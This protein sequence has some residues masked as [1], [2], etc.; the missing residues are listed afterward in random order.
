MSPK[1]V[2]KID[3]DKINTNTRPVKSDK[4]SQDENRSDK[5]KN[6]K[7]DKQN[8]QK[9]EFNDKNPKQNNAEQKSNPTTDSAS[10]AKKDKKQK[11]RR[12]N[13]QP[14]DV[15][16]VIKGQNNQNNQN[17]TKPGKNSKGKNKSWRAYQRTSE[18]LPMRSS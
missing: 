4:K 7:K 8:R 2:G 12:I 13:E 3:L 14:V 10:N 9:A 16:A 18:G 15:E 1:V 6:K 17:N 11:R 5:G